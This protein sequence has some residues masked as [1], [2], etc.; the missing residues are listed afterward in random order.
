MLQLKKIFLF[1]TAQTHF[2]YDGEYFHEVEVAMGSPLGPL[3]A[4]LFMGVHEKSWLML[5]DGPSILFYWRYVDDI[6]CLVESHEHVAP[7]LDYL[8]SK[9]D[10]INVRLM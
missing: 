4:N 8:N 10:N 7:F 9:H 5:Y 2:L 6:F 1:A 3:L